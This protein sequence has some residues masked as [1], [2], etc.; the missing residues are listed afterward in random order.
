[1]YKPKVVITGSTGLIGTRVV[2]L[3]SDRFEFIPL[4]QEDGFDITDR[5]ATS[6]KLQDARFDFLLHLAAY[7]NVDKAEE[8]RELCHRINVIGTQNLLEICEIKKAKMLLVSTDYVLD[9]LTPEPKDENTPPHPLGYYGQTKLEAEQLIKGKGM[10]VRLTSPYR[11]EFTPKKDLVR[12]LKFLLET[13]KPLSMV[14]DNL[15]VPTF[16]DDI[17]DAFGYL[18]QHFSS[19]IYHIVGPHAHSTYDV[20]VHIARHYHLNTSLI[21]RTMYKDYSKGRTATRPQYA[22]IITTKDLGVKMKGLEEGL[23]HCS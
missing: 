23:V 20:A 5:E 14:S 6:S 19:E 16:V 8:E 3:L 4:R 2:D 22:N 15:I 10:I 12:T 9:G 7:T 1:M 13:G 11:A 17:A 21:T 18:M